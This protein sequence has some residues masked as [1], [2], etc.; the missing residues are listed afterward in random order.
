MI[1]EVVVHTSGDILRWAPGAVFVTLLVIGVLGFV[2]AFYPPPTNLR[3]L[4][5]PT[6]GLRAVQVA[7][8]LLGALGAIARAFPFSPAKDS[9]IPNVDG[10]TLGFIGVIVAAFYLDQVKIKSLKFAGV[11]VET[12]SEE[13]TT[14]VDESVAAVEVLGRLFQSWPRT[15]AT[16]FDNFALATDDEA[17]TDLLR[18]FQRDRLGDAKQF[19]A[20]GIS[21]RIRLSFWL[22]N[23]DE[24][25]IRFDISNDINDDQTKN[26]S[27]RPG[28]GYL[29]RAFQEGQTLNSADATM[30]PS[31]KRIHDRTSYRGVL[32]TPV[33]LGSLKLGVLTIDRP[34]AETFSDAGVQIAEACSAF[35]A[36]ALY[37]Y[38]RINDDRRSTE[39]DTP[40]IEN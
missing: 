16:L 27:F 10:V 8:T 28:E 30:L 34:E 23:P 26:A 40:I 29:G 4:R 38:N 15:I 2:L 7:L 6:A 37:E 9:A 17:L 39:V 19:I 3:T 11:E 20:A 36:L 12:F 13:A 22:Y 24:A 21:D 18:N 31:F 35:L 25:T 33:S 32:A 14:A 5:S 1:L